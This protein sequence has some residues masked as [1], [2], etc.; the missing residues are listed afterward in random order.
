[1]EICV[2]GNVHASPDFFCAVQRTRWMFHDIPWRADAFTGSRS[3]LSG[4]GMAIKEFEGLQLG[5]TV[6]EWLR[7][8]PAILR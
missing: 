8:C 5:V 7:R 1:M 2:Y 4:L 3:S 6:A